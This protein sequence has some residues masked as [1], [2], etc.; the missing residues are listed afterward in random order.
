MRLGCE[1]VF[2]FK[3][4]TAYEMRIS[5]WSSDV[6][7]SDLLLPLDAFDH[8]FKPK[9]LN[10]AD[11]RAANHSGL[12]RIDDIADQR[13]VDLYTIDGKFFQP[14]QIGITRTEIVDSDTY[15]LLPQSAELHQNFVIQFHGHRFG[16]L[17]PKLRCQNA[18][19]LHGT[20]QTEN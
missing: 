19:S 11:D 5:D 20:Q 16:D 14:R 12:R 2:C 13:A 17:Q 9:F 1:Y 3:Q 15:A 8:H 7:S 10:D 18:V 4:K 6:C